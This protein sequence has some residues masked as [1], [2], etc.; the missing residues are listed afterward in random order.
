MIGNNQYKNSML[1]WLCEM[2]KPKISNIEYI[3]FLPYSIYF[4]HYMIQ[5]KSDTSLS[6]HIAPLSLS[7]S[8]DRSLS[9][10]LIHVA[11][12]IELYLHHQH[13]LTSTWI[14]SLKAIISSNSF[15]KHALLFASSFLFFPL[16]DQLAHLNSHI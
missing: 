13:V 15:E 16:P 5:L 2:W 9:L 4:Y 7:Y 14:I 1:Q 3:D 12:S 6:I 8:L 10:S 11:S